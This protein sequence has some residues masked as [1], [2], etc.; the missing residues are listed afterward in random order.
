[1]FACVYEGVQ[2]RGKLKGLGLIGQLNFGWGDNIIILENICFK[3]SLE[4]L[5]LA[6]TTQLSRILA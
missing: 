1:M 6:E 2:C 5:F 3:K 4:H